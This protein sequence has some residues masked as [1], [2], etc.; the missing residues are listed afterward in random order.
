MLEEVNDVLEGVDE[1]CEM[2]LAIRSVVQSLREQRRKMHE[3]RDRWR[4]NYL[5]IRLF[6]ERAVL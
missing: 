6:L 5:R 1:V 4:S 2:W 3:W